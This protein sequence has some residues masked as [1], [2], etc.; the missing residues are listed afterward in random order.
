MLS[1]TAITTARSISTLTVGEL[2]A[3]MHWG[4]P[5]SAT[6]EQALEAI[7]AAEE[8]GA[9][10]AAT[11]RA[12]QDYLARR[13]QR[14]QDALEAAAA[15]VT[16]GRAGSGERYAARTEARREAAEAFERSE[17]QLDFQDWID[18]GRPD[19]HTVGVATRALNRVKAATA[20]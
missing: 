2:R 13:A 3:V 1:S 11:W 10:H 5:E 6:V 19:V 17:P 15:R 9:A 7:A 4:G 18:A 12:Y 8:A 16:R 20:S 14:R